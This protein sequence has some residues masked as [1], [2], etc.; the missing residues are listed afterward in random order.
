MKWT[1][2]NLKSPNYTENHEIYVGTKTG[3]FKKLLPA[4]EDKPFKQSNLQDLNELDKDSHITSLSF[5]NANKSEILIGRGKSTAQVHSVRTGHTQY[6]IDFEES[7]IVGLARYDNCVVAGFGNG[8][9]R[10]VAINDDGDIDEEQPKLLLDKVGDDMSRL[11]QCPSDRNIVAVGGK[12]RQNNLKIFDMAAGGKQLF[13]SKNLPNDYLQ[14]EVPIWDCDVGFFDSP[15]TLATC[16]RYGYVRLYDT[17]KQRRPV[18]CYATE[19]Q[20]SFTTLAANGNYIYTGTTMGAL[21]AFDIRRMKTFVHTYKG[22][23]GGISDLHLDASGKY[24]ASAC[25][26][27]YVRVHNVDSCVMLYQCYVKSKATRV[28]L[29]ESMENPN[30]AEDGEELE[31]DENGGKSKGSNK[32]KANKTQGGDVSEDE[33]YENMFDN[34][35]TICDNGND[36][37]D[38]EDNSDDDN[39]DGAGDSSNEEEPEEKQKSSKAGSKRKAKGNAIKNKKKRN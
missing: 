6:T 13:T 20:M 9:I 25:L 26:D 2:A 1:T 36:A 37:Q 28:L 29:R 17:R 23:T 15:H 30:A 16:S 12:G 4:Y 32:K 24:L 27:R 22:F 10:S 19:D 31:D 33:E 3:T 18:Q 39:G 38:D 8:H 7:P 5:A 11:R 34:M 35:Q 21:K 14:L